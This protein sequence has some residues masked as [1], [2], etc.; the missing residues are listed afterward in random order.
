VGL[1]GDPARPGLHRHAPAGAKGCGCGSPI[2]SFPISISFRRMPTRWQLRN[3]INR[4]QATT[5]AVPLDDTHTMQIGLLPD[6]RGQGAAARLRF[7]ARMPVAPMK[8]GSGY[9]AI[10]DAQVS[11]HG[12]MARHGLEH[13]AATDRGIIMMRKHDP[14]R[15]S[16]GRQG[17]GAG[18][19]PCCA[20]GRQVPTYSH[21]RVVSG[22]APAPTAEADRPIAAQRRAKCGQGNGENR[23][24]RR[25]KLRACGWTAR[26]RQ[27]PLARSW[28]R[29]LARCPFRRQTAKELRARGYLV[30]FL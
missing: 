6:T 8:S 11:I 9:P 15:H 22:I 23:L 5:W 10:Y 19:R 24:A 27:Y 20:T 2:S 30:R 4:P 18:N 3:S 1:D 14:A 28:P 29:P 17:R 12:S 26:R 21:D 13:L 7:R 16:H 25:L